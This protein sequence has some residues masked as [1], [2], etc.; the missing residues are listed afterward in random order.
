MPSR[1]LGTILA[2]LFLV[3]SAA[4]LYAQSTYGSISGTV[5]DPS[6]AAVTGATITLTN[7]STS[8]KRTQASGDDGHYTFVNLFQGQYRVD[9]EKQGFK[10]FD[11][12]SVV[13]QVQQDTHVDAVLPVGQVSETVEVSAE[14]PLLQT[15]S[16][17]LG[18]VVEQRKANELP[19]NGRNIFNLITISPAAVAQGGSGGSP[20]GQ[21]PFSWGNYQIGGSFANQGAEYLDGQPLNIGYINLP[22]I[23]PTQ[24]SIG[25]FKV[26]YSNLG[27]EWGK[28]SGGVT[29]LSTKGGSNGF[30]GSAYEYFRN[31]VLNA[32]E[33]FNK[34]HE[35]A[36]GQPNEAPP[37]TQNQYG[38]EVGGP[39]IKNKTFFYVSWEQYRQRTG[40]PFTTTVPATGMLNGDFSSLCTASTAQG[41]AG[42]TLNASG[43]CSNPA[44][45]IY[46][47]FST[48]TTGANARAPFGLDSTDPTCSG[49]CVPSTYFSKA[50]TTMWTKYYPAQNVPGNV[51]N[52]Y[53]SVAPA[54]GNT[55][56][57]VARG[58]Q[59]LGSNTRVFGRFAYYGLLDL[60]VN[61]FGTGL[62][63]DRC[64][65]K[66]HSKLLVFGVN[67]AFTPNTILDVNFGGTRFVYS[68]QPLLSGYD[69]T[70]LGW[71]S[72]Y[73]SPP[74]TMRTPPT[75]EFPFPNDVGH[76]QG[77]SAIGDHNTQYNITPA[78]TMIRGKHTIQA[79]VQFEYG[80]DN[81]FQTNIASGAFGFQGN[82]TSSS[83]T[84]TDGSGF[85][86]AD[87]LLG[88][89][90]NQGSFAGNQTEGVAQVPA[91]TKGLQVYRAFYADD[92]WHI[93]PKFTL[94]LG[95]RYELQGTWSDAYNRLSYFDPSATNATVT[96]CPSGACPGDAFLVKSGRNG[97][98]N[99]IP[100]DKKAFSPRLGFAYALDS[101]T[102]IRGGY[103]IFYIPNYVS[104]GLNPDNDVVNLANTDF[105]A[106]TDSYLTP[107][108]TLDGYNCS[109]GATPGVPTCLQ[110]GP[111]GSGGI[112]APPGRNFS[113]LPATPNVSSFVAS[114]NGPT[115]AP[116]FG[117][118]GHSDPKYGYV[119][120]WN[121]DIQRQLPAGFFAD[122]AYAGSHGVHLQ[123]YSTNINQIGDSFVAQAASQYNAAAPGCA[124]AA[125]PVAC[126]NAAVSI[127][128]TVANPLH[129][130]PNATLALPTLANQGQLD[131]PYPQYLGMNL[132]G[133]GCCG[134]SYNSLQVAVTRR[135]QG[136]GTLLVAYTNAK[137]MSN[138]DT[139]TSWLEGPTG[140]VPGV[141]D[142]NN[143]KGDRSLSAQDVSQRLVI[144]YVLDLPFGKGKAYA[145]SLSGVAN[146]VVSGWGV[147]GITTFQ[148]G[149]PLK[150]GWSGP[151]T[152]LE[153]G[154]FGVANIRPD[155]IPGCNKK[156]GGAK[157][158]EYF[159]TS[160]FAPPPQWGYGTESRVDGILRGPGIN[161]FDFAIFKR[162][163][164]GE[165]VGVE[166]RTEFFNIFNHPYFSQP[167]TGY[168]G[169][170]S[171]NGFGQITST[172]QGG[173]ASPERLI[174][175]ALKF[176]F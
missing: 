144:S 25:E 69:L 173:V 67:H 108:S 139:L 36:N 17:S 2:S 81:Y 83:P 43:I 60:P 124:S 119:E 102:S 131:R 134:S 150:I 77:N 137:L 7:L 98:R 29:N 95:L 133:Y 64:A 12:P 88:V 38:F 85:P 82:W 126:A 61:P 148:R 172:I 147:N 19:L 84:A 160:C 99:N 80:L 113:G 86:T 20:V 18:Q 97:S 169:T 50:A 45:Q 55:N 158:T 127:N 162:T 73:N 57:F 120:Q 72:T 105:T 176:I 93:T 66:Y 109:L 118:N 129:G 165:R 41:G 48:G 65:E 159:N 114:Q 15:E 138:T 106:S 51:I 146:G 35:L 156:S 121:F 111:F 110:P 58:D 10:H 56:E 123:Q 149:F 90:L 166:F 53:L 96:G 5:T 100:M 140:G 115:L 8:E 117:L 171:G 104:F 101:K 71:P 26:Q 153:S 24:D 128:Q 132:A 44:G 122:V 94:N 130:S 1:I 107:F 34:Q 13:V 59:N 157:L 33:Y 31:K 11:R 116:Y 32:N 174:Q 103:G 22:I 145:S 6:G 63:L 47:P 163:N 52:N 136:G 152:S 125:N 40:S 89:G 142:W 151:S 141:Q 155:V 161:N 28:F 23:I 49:N 76:S 14:T 154:S 92:T 87:F 30:H 54:G 68:R 3:F 170:T 27:A 4:T 164:I 74:S 167:G 9:V 62:C 75:P 143:L 79:G 70:A 46:N 112:I 91:Q 168:N 21:N 37:W 78:L 135:F 175:F 16:S 39:V 42:G